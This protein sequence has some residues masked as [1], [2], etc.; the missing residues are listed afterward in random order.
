MWHLKRKHNTQR[1]S[2]YL[3]DEPRFFMLK[4]GRTPREAVCPKTA[5]QVSAETRATMRRTASQCVSTAPRFLRNIGEKHI[6]PVGRRAIR[7][8]PPIFPSFNGTKTGP[9]PV[10]KGIQAGVFAKNPVKVA[11]I[12]KAAGRGHLCHGQFG[13]R[14]HRLR[15]HDADTVNIGD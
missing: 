1:G 4:H 6:L 10:G 14:Q 12:R 3:Q 7:T 15:P 8:T 2:S 11:G 5:R 9:F 13:A